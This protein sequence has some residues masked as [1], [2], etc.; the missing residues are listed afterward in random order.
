LAPTDPRPKLRIS[1]KLR[2]AG[3]GKWYLQS[4]QYA[5]W[6]AG[7]APFTWLYGSAGSGKT[8]LSAGIIE[9]MQRHCNDDLAR[10]L[11]F[12]FFD[13]HDTEKQNP[14]NMLRSLLSQ[15]LN[16][17]TRIPEAVQSLHHTC[18]D[19]RRKASEQQLLQALK[20]TLEIFPEPF[21]ILDALDECSDWCTL[22]DI[23]EEMQSW[24]RTTPR[25]LMTSRKET[26][27]EKALKGVVLADNRLCLET[28]LVD[29]DIGTYVRERLANDNAFERWQNDLEVREEIKTH[30]GRKA[31]GMYSPLSS[32]ALGQGRC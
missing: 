11:A 26:K 1:L 23:V 32:V 14:D 25:V 29:K 5:E 9:D 31:G 13:F 21:V 19:G 17:C 27:I 3:T 12:F 10:S 4:A 28:S 8:I 6:K 18:E 20:G 30:L 16:R 24:S 2:S 22:Q 7:R 15:F